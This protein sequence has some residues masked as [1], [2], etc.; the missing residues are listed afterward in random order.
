MLQRGSAHVLAMSQTGFLHD[1]IAHTV[2]LYFRF[3]LSF[4]AVEELLAAR[5]VIVTYETVRQWSGIL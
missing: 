2:W 4:R 3:N 1:I 5:D